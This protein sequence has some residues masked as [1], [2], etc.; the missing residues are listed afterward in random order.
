M[1]VIERGAAVEK[2]VKDNP[3]MLVPWYLI[4]SYLYYRADISLVPDSVYDS[5]CEEL[6]WVLPKL[7]HRH[8]RLV[9]ADAL[10]AGTGFQIRRYPEIVSGAATALAREDGY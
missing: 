1:N 5:I 6:G 4:L 10:L 2:L 8:K 7:T 9:D 3:N